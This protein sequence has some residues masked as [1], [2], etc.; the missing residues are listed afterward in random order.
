MRNL[1]ILCCL[2]LSTTIFSQQVL[3]EGG[4]KA[5]GTTSGQVLKYNG[6][7]WVAGTDNSG[8]DDQT[9][10]KGSYSSPTFSGKTITDGVFRRGKIA[11]FTSTD[12]VGFISIRSNDTLST[13]PFL[14]F[15]G[16]NELGI[17]YKADTRSTIGTDF[18]IVRKYGSSGDGNQNN[19][20]FSI[21]F[22]TTAGGGRENSAYPSVR[23]AIEENFRN[24]PTNFN[25]FECHLPDI[26][27]T[28]G[29]NRRPISGYYSRSGVNPSGF[30]G[31][32]QD[33]IIFQDY[34]NV[35]AKATWSFRS[36][37]PYALGI[38]FLDSA[39]VWL[40]KNN[41]AGFYQRRADGNADVKIAY[42]NDLNEV[43]LGQENATNV[44]AYNLLKVSNS[45]EIFNENG[46]LYVGSTARPTRLIVTSDNTIGFTLQKVGNAYS[47]T[48]GLFSQ[49]YFVTC[50]QTGAT[51]F[52]IDLTAAEYAFWLKASDGRLGLGL[53][54]PTA[55]L[56]LLS[57]NGATSSMIALANTTGL[58]NI[59][60]SDASPEGAITASPGDLLLSNISGAGGL[61]QKVT[62][63]NSNTGWAQ[64]YNL[65][66]SHSAS[67]GQV[68]QWNGTTWGPTTITGLPS[69]TSGQTLRHN[70]SNWV[71]N[72]TLFNNGTNVGI[73]TTSP[74]DPL[75]VSGTARATRFMVDEASNHTA[76][77]SKVSGTTSWQIDNVSSDLWYYD[78]DSY[79]IVIDNPSGNMGIGNTSPSDKLHVTG[80]VRIEGALK[81]GT[82]SAGTS[83]QVLK[84]TGTTTSW[85]S[86]AP[87]EL[88]QSGATSGQVIKWNGT[89]WAP[90]ADAGDNW[91][92]QSV[93]T[94]AR[95]TGNGVSGTPLEL[96]QQSATTG[97]VLAWS[98]TAWA[99]STNT[100][101]STTIGP[102]QTSS[103]TNG[104][105]LSGTDIRLHS[106]ASSN[107]GAVDLTSGQVLGNGQKIIQENLNGET[108]P[109]IL[110]NNQAAAA[111]TGTGLIFQA[112][113]TNA[114]MF[115][116]QSDMVSG[117]T[118]SGAQTYI[119][120]RNSSNGMSTHVTFV[121]NATT[122]LEGY[123]AVSTLTVTANYNASSSLNNR[124]G[125]YCISTAGVTLTLP[126]TNVTDG[127]QILVTNITTSGA[128]A[129]VNTGAGYSEFVFDYDLDAGTGGN[130][131]EAASLSIPSGK[132]YMLVSY[133][134]SSN[135][136]WR[137]CLL[138]SAASSGGTTYT[139]GAFQ[140]TGTANAASI[141]GSDIRIHSAS[142]TTPGAVDLTDNQ[143]LGANTKIL[144]EASAGDVSTPLILR[145]PSASNDDD[146]TGIHL[147]GNTTTLSA[148]EARI[149]GGGVSTGSQLEISTRNGDN[150]LRTGLV[151]NQ[152]AYTVPQSWIGGTN[153][154]I[155]TSLDVS[156]S[157]TNRKTNFQFT[158]AGA[159]LTLPINNVDEGTTVYIHS[160]YESGAAST[161]NTGAAYSE[162]AYDTDQDAGT[163]GNQ[164]YTSTLS[165]APMQSITLKALT[166][167]GSLRWKVMLDGS[168][169]GGGG[170]SSTTLDDAYNNFGA[171]AS[172]VN[173][174]AA[175]GQTGGL[176]FELG[177][178]NFVVDMQ[179]TGDIIFQDASVPRFQLFDNG[180]ASFGNIS[181]STSARL[182]VAE[183]GAS[184][185]STPLRADNGATVTDGGGTQIATAYN[186]GD[187]LILKAYNPSGSYNN[188][189]AIA[190]TWGD[191]VVITDDIRETRLMAAQANEVTTASGTTFQIDGR[192][193]VIYVP[194]SATTT[195]VTLPE[196][197][198]G[199][200]ST[201][202]VNPGYLVEIYIDRSAQVTINR[203]GASDT[204]M[205]DAESATAT[206]LT[207]TASKFFCK[208]LRALAADRWALIQ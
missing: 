100:S 94:T 170:S 56:H 75:T 4:V 11:L 199:A 43:V 51:P 53:P 5:P 10:G 39:G 54:N 91:G 69:G 1:L 58:S 71:A 90:A 147:Q 78:G 2:L 162:F 119:T 79:S 193:S 105:S 188:A 204:I 21:G 49:Q 126:N 154:L 76:L 37:S 9:W 38:R 23:Y 48:H 203:S 205:V 103:T 156:S 55:K 161:V 136:Y 50:P 133:T 14:Y 181:P 27:Y 31:F 200:A 128:D 22:N 185:I 19:Q 186:G 180:Y 108:Q 182:T 47:A 25:A 114:N 120:N 66:V 130:Q 178:A 121:P 106:A 125:H 174:D 74:S 187:R 41:Y 81:D 171:T 168:S 195:T 201:N 62:G 96:A 169:S 92:S 163:G 146:G 3:L 59:F 32:T 12:T 198:T 102:F 24:G 191:N 84:S 140:T 98:G 15:S 207:T 172:K 150:T 189:A 143:I 194:S 28:N 197:V 26:S 206:S 208:K 70:G 123:N 179:S 145:N 149:T 159:T 64:F 30:T 137:V 83:N 112:S 134:V 148:L 176:E 73:G 155:S 196:I 45:G 6:T 89:N 127:T 160:L 44:T 60:R 183:D 152:N 99:P 132:G 57:G 177:A 36:P 131:F 164:F 167:G 65:G 88:S 141:S 138:P 135:T 129:T 46:E 42:V 111:D 202:Q 72:S 139:I 61:W 18:N 158:A 80:A 184:S 95:F 8:A 165:V 82:N 20:I 173:V 16:N 13:S 109:L 35:A 142:N 190:T 87:S 118:T 153:S 107:P 122:R 113:S 101:E 86:V 110:R 157:L 85:G 124:Y 68:M 144:S 116:I 117:T 115:Q 29:A 175:Q 17:K 151:V 104:I 33:Y 63:T 67:T 77:Q 97:Q 52:R 7:T 166:V 93:V 40:G 192:T 34:R